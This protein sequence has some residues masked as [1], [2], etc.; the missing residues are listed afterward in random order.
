MDRTD[1]LFRDLHEVTGENHTK[2][3][4]N[5]TANVPVRPAQLYNYSRTG[6][7][8]NLYQARRNGIQTAAVRNASYTHNYALRLWQRV[9]DCVKSA[10]CHKGQ[11]ALPGNLKISC[12]EL[13]P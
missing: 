10:A 4:P 8:K 3:K 12:P 9:N 1:L 11:R 13:S 7:D 6:V 2:P 5:N